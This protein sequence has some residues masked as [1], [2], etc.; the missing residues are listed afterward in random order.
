MLR[1]PGADLLRWVTA[2][3]DKRVLCGSMKPHGIFLYIKDVGKPRKGCFDMD[4]RQ[5]ELKLTAKKRAVS[6]ENS[7]GCAFAG[8]RHLC[9][10]LANPVCSHT[11]ETPCPFRKTREQHEE[12]I[13]KHDERMNHLP[14]YAQ[15]AYAERYHGG[16]MPWKRP[17]E[18]AEDEQKE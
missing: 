4:F 8:N 16:K 9:R 14:A 18:R 6:E 10:A 13:R 7:K 12:S 1:L 2:F 15:K 5:A 3:G 17:A 11:P